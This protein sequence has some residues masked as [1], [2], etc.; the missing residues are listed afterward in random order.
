MALTT[1]KGALESILEG[2]FRQVLFFRAV[3]WPTLKLLYPEGEEPPSQGEFLKPHVETLQAL[4][5]SALTV[6]PLSV[7]LVG[8]RSPGVARLLADRW[9]EAG[10]RW[11]KLVPKSCPRHLTPTHLI[12]HNRR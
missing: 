4:A 1:E 10:H 6:D 11:P 7:D 2:R 9:L 3:D 5:R 8:R 12:S